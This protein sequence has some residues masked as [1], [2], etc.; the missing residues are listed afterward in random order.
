MTD[1][2]DETALLRAFQADPGPESF[3]RLAERHLP[4]VWS[5]ARRVLAD[6]PAL[7]EDAVQLVLTD[8][9]RRAE[10]L[11]PDGSLGG[12]LH[13]HTCFTASKL[14][15]T[16]HR[17]R[18]RESAAAMSTPLTSPPSTDDPWRELAPHVDAA[19]ASLPETDRTA[20]VLRFFERQE[21]QAVGRVLG[22]SDEAAR[23]RVDRAL[24]SLRKRLVRAGIALPAV[25]VGYALAANALAAPPPGW[26]AGLVTAAWNQRGIGAG[27]G[28]TLLS[29]CAV[30]LSAPW[31][32]PAVGVVVAVGGWVWWQRAATPLATGS[33]APVPAV[34]AERT[35]PPGDPLIAEITVFNVEPTQVAATL[36]SFVPGRDDP[37]LWGR[38]DAAAAP[39]PALSPEAMAPGAVRPVLGPVVRAAAFHQTV[40]SGRRAKL[41]KWI[42]FTYATEYAAPGDSGDEGKP[43]FWEKV[44]LGTGAEVVLGPRRADG[45]RQAHVTLTHH[46]EPPAWI[47]WPTRVWEAGASEGGVWLPGLQSVSLEGTLVLPP[48]QPRLVASGTVPP[49]IES[50]VVPPRQVLVF[51]RFSDPAAP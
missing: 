17:R 16:E 35:G 39:A 30:W 7:V 28:S 22:L 25:A 5:V 45:R 10:R 36:R 12:W 50:S 49:P 37:A 3:R 18:R 2:P 26:G 19:L 34:V 24:A 20:I 47:H 21:Y 11:K 44:N 29:R 40:T 46:F 14:R 15:R 43:M 51:A 48:G 9:A 8:L 42:E 32:W 41:E 13:R 27:A 23:K 6:E 38:L 1:R 33:G 31:L 4:L